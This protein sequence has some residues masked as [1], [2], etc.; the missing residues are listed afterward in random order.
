MGI[1]D[2]VPEMFLVTPNGRARPPS[3]RKPFK[4]KRARPIKLLR[5]ALT[6][7]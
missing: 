4:V 2:Y 6:F 1:V 7:S 3:T 5:S